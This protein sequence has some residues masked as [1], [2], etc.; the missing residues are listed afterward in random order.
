MGGVRLVTVQGDLIEATGAISGGYLETGANARGADNAAELK[1]LGD[2][3]RAKSAVRVRRARAE[4]ASSDPRCARSGD[5]LAKRTA[6]GPRPTNRPA[7][8]WR[9]SWPRPG[10]ARR[11]QEAGRRI[12]VRPRSGRGGARE[13]R[14]A[15]HAARDVGRRGEERPSPVTSRSTSGT[16]PRPFPRRS[17]PS[18]RRTRPRTTSGSP[19]SRELEALRASI[20]G[21][22]VSDRRPA[23]PSS[24]DCK[25]S[26]TQKETLLQEVESNRDAAKAALETMR[27]VESKQL[28]RVKE[29]SEE[30]RK[31]D[32]RR[33]KLVDQ[34]ARAQESLRTRSTMVD[35]EQVRL[36]QAEAAPRRGRSGAEGTP[37]SGR[38]REARLGRGTQADDPDCLG[39]ARVDGFG[40]P[41]GPRRVR[42]RKRA[43][44]TSSRAR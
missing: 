16:S 40:Q 39:A 28:D 31:L 17:A 13:G 4:L 25:R 6:R 33:L 38:G 37:G 5:E 21:G 36:Q 19:S 23:A 26:R 10:T 35:Q 14:R 44:S 1:R 7:R 34:L 2:E 3:L 30:K 12:A 41:S 32:E 11:G 29:Q 18:R 27:S 43:G 42:R 15:R 22:R 24:T 20:A 9:R 8:Y